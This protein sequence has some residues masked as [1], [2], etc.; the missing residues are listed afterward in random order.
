MQEK[1]SSNS[2][3]ATGAALA[4]I[5]APLE[6]LV[7]QD[8]TPEQFCAVLSKIFQMQSTEVAL[9]RLEDGRLRFLFPSELKTAGSI[10]LSSASAIAAHTAVSKKAETYN[11]FATVKHASVFEMVKLGQ[12]DVNPSGDRM[13][14]QRLM[15]APVFDSAGNVLGVIQVCRKGLG[16]LS[17]GPEFSAEDMRQL[18]R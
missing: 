7:S 4:P 11:T 10:P 18:E 17:S 15:S 5:L 13:P 3:A 8:P 2:T 9:L 16:L 6:N 12:S 14:I 1:Q